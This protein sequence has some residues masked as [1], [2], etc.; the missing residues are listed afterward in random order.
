LVDAKPVSGLRSETDSIR[1]SAVG[2]IGYLALFLAPIMAAYGAMRAGVAPS[3]ATLACSA[4]AA[5][6]LW[7][8]ERARPA[9]PAW[10]RSGPD[11]RVDALHLT[12]G[13]AIA[14]GLREAALRAGAATLA[15]RAGVWPQ[16]WPLVVQVTLALVVIELVQYV[17]HRAMHERPWLWPLHAVHHSPRRLYWLNA[18]RNHPVDTA[19][20]VVLPLVAVVLLGASEPV[21]ALA[22]LAVG[23]HGMLQH[24]NV[25]VREGA[26]PW[27]FSAAS[28]HRWHHDRD[29]SN[30]HG[31]YGGTLILWDILFGTRRAPSGDGPE[32]LGLSD[33]EREIPER[34]LAQLA[35]PFVTLYARWWRP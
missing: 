27:V 33:G 30:A 4:L 20:T 2:P 16:R 7:A 12:V 29:L 24:C 32:S 14:G 19:L 3:F 17:A 18:F 21:I 10:S 5:V 8:L 1:A 25:R 26:L 35:Y 13:G 15:G 28:L 34:Y 11:V 6:A 23:V 9:R 22:G 31:N